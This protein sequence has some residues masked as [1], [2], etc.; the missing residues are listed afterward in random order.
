MSTKKAKKP[1]V[2]RAKPKL[3]ITGTSD[4]AK[5]AATK[6]LGI[7]MP[8]SPEWAQATD[9]HAALQ[10]V[11]S[12]SDAL[13]ANAVLATNLRTQLA[14]VLAKQFALRSDWTVAVGK[15][16]STVEVFCNGQAE[17]VQAFGFDVHQRVA[18][19]PQPAP[20]NLTVTT[21]KDVGQVVAAWTKGTG[22]HGFVVQHATD[23]SNPATYSA[24]E[25]CTTPHVTLRG[26]PSGSV[27]HVRV[28]A[29]DPKASPAM[30]PWSVW[31]SGTVR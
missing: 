31:A 15:L 24:I 6:A 3:R 29:V 30:G 13:D 26:L 10:L 18:I 21:G 1:R 4:K 12:G 2:D 8:Q 23:P 20:A 19:G 22:L 7:S 11:Q 17:R 9:A 5:V 14:T 28:A 16:L 25:P 27:V